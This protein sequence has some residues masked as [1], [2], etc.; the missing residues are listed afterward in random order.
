MTAP[1]AARRAMVLALACAP[2]L[3]IAAPARKRLGI[4]SVED[5][6]ATKES[7]ADVLKALVA[8]G[9]EEGKRLELLVRFEA[10]DGRTTD[11]R[12]RDIVAWRPDAI[13]TQGTI[14][15]AAARRATRT[16][17]IVT[18][19]A[20]PVGAGFAESIRRPG[21][22][23]TGLSQGI[24]ETS[25]KAM[26][27]LKLIIPGLRRIALLDREEPQARLIASYREKAAREV[28]LEPVMVASNSPEEMTAVLRDLRARKIEAAFWGLA[29]GHPGKIAHDAVRA[30][31]PLVTSVESFVEAGMLASLGH[32]ELDY[33]PRTA[34]VIEQ[35]FRGA[36]PAE[37]PFQYPERFRFVLNRRTAEML[38]IAVRPE[39]LLRAD[40]VIDF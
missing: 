21:G 7:Y 9:F 13:L 18:T 6:P 14:A 30:R 5:G 15:T 31:V 2:L 16:I 29:P 24:A 28:G 26:E 17:P 36:N 12:A 22:N 35:V 20:D 37:L 4:L 25:A 38:G 39:L 34:T 10:E 27:L 33:G 23:I 11:D 19:V 8:R 32:S 1:A 40:R 3:A